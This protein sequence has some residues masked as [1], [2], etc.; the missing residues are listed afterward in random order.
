MCFY[1]FMKYF[2]L[3][4]TLFSFLLSLTSC[5]NNLPEDSLEIKAIK[6]YINQ[7]CPLS[8]SLD[9]NKDLILAT[10][11]FKD[12]ITDLSEKDKEILLKISDL[13]KMCN[14][15][16]LLLGFSSNNEINGNPS[17]AAS[18]SYNRAYN[19]YTYLSKYIK[20]NQLSYAFCGNLRH[21]Y[22]ENNN[23]ARFGNQRVEV[24]M[25]GSSVNSNLLTCLENIK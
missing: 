20:A 10:L 4:F 9:I 19:T 1:L 14:N 6:N 12:K 23:T 2:F 15:K 7:S 22:I 18:L 5:K 21:K 24:V 8:S 16:I 11:Y 13:F 17:I 25:V 3:V